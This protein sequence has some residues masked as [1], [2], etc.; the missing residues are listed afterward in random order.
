MRGGEELNLSELDRE[1]DEIKD[2]IEVIADDE[3]P[4]PRYTF[5]HPEA[6]LSEAEKR[7]LI[8]GIARTF[9]GEVDQDLRGQGSF[10]GFH[11]HHVRYANILNIKYRGLGSSR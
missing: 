9:G 3:M 11:A 6:R 5:I 8:D 10:P 1:Q 2:L 4:P 7:A